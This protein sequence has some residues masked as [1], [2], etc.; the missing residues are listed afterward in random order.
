MSFV[1]PES[2]RPYLK[3]KKRNSRQR[4]PPEATASPR[5]A[6]QVVGSGEG[7]WGLPRALLLYTE[8][9][10]YLFNCPEG[11][12]RILSHQGP[13]RVFANLDAVFCT[14]E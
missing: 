10:R 8:R 13:P 6:F 4:W 7:P 5:V 14:G 11:T 3:T 12:Q 2:S 9:A 1:E